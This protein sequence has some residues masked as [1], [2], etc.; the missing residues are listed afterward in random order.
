MNRDLVS[1]HDGWEK[2]EVNQLLREARD[3][4]ETAKLEDST[5]ILRMEM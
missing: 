1:L 5:M 4:A 3:L 2:D